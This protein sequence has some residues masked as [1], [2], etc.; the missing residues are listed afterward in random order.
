MPSPFARMMLQRKKFITKSGYCT[1]MTGIPKPLPPALEQSLRR[2]L[3]TGERLL[4]SAQPIGKRLKSGFGIWLFAI[5]WTA[6]A[7]FWESLA[8]L[9][10]AASTHTP[11]AFAY[12]FGIVM[13]LFGL[14]FI[15]IGFWMLWKP[16]REMRLA[17]STVFGLTDRRLIRVEEGRKR[18]VSTVLLDQIGP[19]DRQEA[20]DGVGNL[21]IQTH[22]SV[23]SEGDRRTERF[24]ILG[25]PDVARLERLILENRR[26]RAEAAP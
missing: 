26:A 9:P 3:V 1:G 6:F 23:D 24:E 11:D 15:L 22:S 14:P 7:L 21:R 17:G 13:P 5:P 18:S 10:W 8:L 12:S 4:W 16:V 25:V 2:E 20:K 19:M